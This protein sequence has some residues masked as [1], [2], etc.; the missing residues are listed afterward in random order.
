MLGY[1]SKTKI[2]DYLLK[3]IDAT[4]ETQIEDWI[5]AAENFINQYTSRVF[6]ADAE[7]SA[8]LY[9]GDNSVSLLID[10]CV[11][12]TKVEVGNDDYGNSFTEVESSGADRYFLEPVN[13]SAREL[14]IRKI[15]LRARVWVEGKQN[16]RITA[17][18]GYSES[19]PSDIEFVATV[20]VAGICNQQ[21]GGGDQI[22]QEKIGNYSVSY[23]SNDTDSIADFK[24]AMQ[25]LDSYKKLNI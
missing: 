5:A 16:N 18:W 7:A 17:K 1:T 8:R 6:I 2:E 13:Y 15:T 9:D 4:F 3:T 14:P 24:R 20:L 21:I 10:D 19:V 12:V 11:E 23:S 22:T 25:I